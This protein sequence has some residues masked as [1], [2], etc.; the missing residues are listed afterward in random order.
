MET[1]WRE[2]CFLKRGMTLY[3][4]ILLSQRKTGLNCW[5]VENID[6]SLSRGTCPCSIARRASGMERKK[7]QH[8][9]IS[10]DMLRGTLVV[11]GVRP[12]FH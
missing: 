1:N 11:F 7:T 10:R 6:C 2:G 5:S 9:S 3:Q 12:Y 4:S 8:P